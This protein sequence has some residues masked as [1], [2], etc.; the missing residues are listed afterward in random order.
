MATTQPDRLDRIESLLERM[1]IES[2]RSKRESNERLTRIE[3]ANEANAQRITELT[4]VV[5]S[6]NRFLESFSQDL[7]RYTD[8]LDRVSQQLA[9]STASANE[10]RYETNTRLSSIIGNWM[11]SP[12]IWG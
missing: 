11:Q 4:Q 1:A 12:V 3:Q 10:D 6:N 9:T 7:K 2:E 8:N 5:A